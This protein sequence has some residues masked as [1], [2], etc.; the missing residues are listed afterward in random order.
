MIVDDN[1]A[2]IGSANINDRSMIGSR[3]SE[4]AMLTEDMNKIPSKMGGESVLVGFFSATLR[5]S[6]Y[7]EHFGM[8]EH[9][10]MDPLSEETENYIH[11]ITSTNTEIYREIFRC[12][13]GKIINKN[14][15]R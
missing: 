5:R 3:D 13:P 1:F 7:Q 9:D 2:I 15:N 4:I 10:S 14:K 11:K 12:Y 8:N 6:L